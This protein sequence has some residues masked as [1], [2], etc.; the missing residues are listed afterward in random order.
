M[1]GISRRRWAVLAVVAVSCAGAVTVVAG[2]EFPAPAATDRQEL[3]TRLALARQLHIDWEWNG[4][5]RPPSFTRRYDLTLLGTTVKGG[6]VSRAEFKRSLRLL[7]EAPLSQ[8]PYV[9]FAD[10]TDDYPKIAIVAG[11]GARRVRFFTRS[12][13]AGHV[14]WAVEI[15]GRTFVV[16]SDAP[17]RVLELL[18]PRLAPP[19]EAERMVG[20]RP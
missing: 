1:A 7:S 8:G 10:H 17:E 9:P 4:Y 19:R 2:E 15:G 3:H 13:G 18:I 5:A 12:Q 6:R 16:A 14:P 11:S 20:R